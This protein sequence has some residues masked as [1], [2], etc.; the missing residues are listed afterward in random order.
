MLRCFFSRP[1]LILFLAIIQVFIPALARPESKGTVNYEI[2]WG[3]LRHTYTYIFSG[4]VRCG[5]ELCSNVRVQVQV[6]PDNSTGAAAETRTDSEGRF[7]VQITCNDTSEDA[8][9]WRIV[10]EA[11]RP[12]GG[13]PVELEGRIIMTADQTTFVVQRPVQI[14]RG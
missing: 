8:A 4:T 2:E 14:N 13:D 1:S 10:A 11:P 6:E 7:E 9:V 3:S 12:G 5:S